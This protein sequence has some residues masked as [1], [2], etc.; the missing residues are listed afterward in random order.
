MENVND[1]ELTAEMAMDWLNS[2]ISNMEHQRQL[3]KLNSRIETI[4][5]PNDIHIYSGIEELA[6]VLGEELTE[7]ERKVDDCLEYF[8]IYN[9][10]R[11]FGIFEE[12]IEKFASTD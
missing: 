7:R 11:V 3:E 5:R 10:V 2:L 4:S 9:G 1:E 6:D 8:F 12:R